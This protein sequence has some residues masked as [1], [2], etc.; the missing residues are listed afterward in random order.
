MSMEN[1]PRRNFLQRLAGLAGV[2]AV[3]AA[4]A[5]AQAQGGGD[6][7]FLPRHARALDYKSLK[8]SSFDR[9]ECLRLRHDR[10]D[11]KRLDLYL[12]IGRLLDARGKCFEIVLCSSIMRGANVCPWPITTIRV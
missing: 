1:A 4:P 11:R 8:Q 3:A 9:I 2:S 6:Y 5:A 10:S 12:P 7:R